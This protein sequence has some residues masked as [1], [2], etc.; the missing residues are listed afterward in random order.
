MTQTEMLEVAYYLVRL[1]SGYERDGEYFLFQF[2]QP[3]TSEHKQK[4]YQLCCET[5]RLRIVRLDR[6]FDITADCAEQGVNAIE[7]LKCINFFLYN[8]TNYDDI[9]YNT[10]R[11]YC[12]GK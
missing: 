3:G 9:D 11:R 8:E 2:N 4:F 7:V 1:R 10:Y 12:E 6:M 5:C